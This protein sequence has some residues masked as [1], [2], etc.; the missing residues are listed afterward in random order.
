MF[1]AMSQVSAHD[2]WSAE[3]TPKLSHATTAKEETCGSDRPC[4]TAGF[5]SKITPQGWR[6]AE[7]KSTCRKHDKCYGTAGTERADC[8]AEFKEGLVAS[9]AC[10]R[11]PRQ[12]E[13]VA[14]I[15]SRVVSKHGEKA[16][17]NAQA[18]TVIDS[19]K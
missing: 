16:F 13:R 8:D 17:N 10:S 7:F 11:R 3:A 5:L 14:R 15:M 19:T 6:G 1:L 12:C 18:N 4:G 2:S 9:C